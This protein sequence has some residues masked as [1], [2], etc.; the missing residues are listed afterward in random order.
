MK[1]DIWVNR[2]IREFYILKQSSYVFS[3]YARGG[4]L[5]WAHYQQEEE[6]INLKEAELG[7]LHAFQ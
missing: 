2:D 1:L 3:K 7:N 6:K 4:F 5:C